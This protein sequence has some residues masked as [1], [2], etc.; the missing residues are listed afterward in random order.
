MGFD[1]TSDRGDSFSASIPQT[2]PLAHSAT[3][4]GSCSGTRANLGNWANK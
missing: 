1:S 4:F 3:S 2:G